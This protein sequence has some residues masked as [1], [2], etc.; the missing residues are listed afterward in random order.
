MILS[1]DEVR[2][3]AIALNSH[4]HNVSQCGFE[5]DDCPSTTEYQKLKIKLEEYMEGWS[6][7]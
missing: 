7:G 5:F 3:A 2:L 1:I 4:I 6:S